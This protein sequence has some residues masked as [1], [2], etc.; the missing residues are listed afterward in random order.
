DLRPGRTPR[1]PS[2][3]DSR[4]RPAVDPGTDTAPSPSRIPPADQPGHAKATPLAP[5]AHA[6]VSR[7]E[8]DL[9]PPQGRV[10]EIDRLGVVHDSLERLAPR[11]AQVLQI[12]AC[13]R[14]GVEVYA[15]G[16]A[17]IDV[18]AHEPLL[19][20]AAQRPAEVTGGKQRCLRRR[21]R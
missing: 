13:L 2:R 14:G 1:P 7:G 10:D 15:S 4:G 21:P 9:D 6:P 12:L 20:E 16:V 8:F 5:V 3:R 11:V 18:A 19:L 17:R